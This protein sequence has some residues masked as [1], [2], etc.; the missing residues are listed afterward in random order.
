MLIVKL[1][2][3]VIVCYFVF[4]FNVFFVLVWIG[5]LAIILIFFVGFVVARFIEKYSCRFV[6]VFGVLLSV[7]GLVLILFVENVIIYFFI[8]GLMGGFGFCCIRILSFLV[9]VRYFYKRKFF[10]IGIL[11]VGGGF[12]LFI[13]VLF[14]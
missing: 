4:N 13:F 7:V 8:Y 6:I 9:M 10:V 14:I 3:R 12:G 2:F 11:I 5:F 1:R